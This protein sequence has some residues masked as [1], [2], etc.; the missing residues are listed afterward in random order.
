M[1]AGEGISPLT[2]STTPVDVVSSAK[3]IMGVSSAGI[4]EVFQDT[5]I[6]VTGTAGDS[7]RMT[8][9]IAR[10]ASAIDIGT[11]QRLEVGIAQFP[12]FVAVTRMAESSTI[13]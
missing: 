12:K 1:G 5:T 2:G 10:R 7:A 6:G 4:W 8:P 13:S 3:L 11:I 9:G